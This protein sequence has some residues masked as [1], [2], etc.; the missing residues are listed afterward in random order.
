MKKPLFTLVAVLLAAA[1][2]YFLCLHLATRQTRR[3]LGDDGDTGA[4]PD[5]GGLG[6]PIREES[7][8]ALVQRRFRRQSEGCSAGGNPVGSPEVDVDR[9][10]LGP[11][12]QD[13]YFRHRGRGVLS[14][15]QIQIG[16]GSAWIR[17]IQRLDRSIAEK[18]KSG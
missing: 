14:Q 13:V 11:G 5:R 10:R 12:I 16:I 17:S 18:K 15:H 2:A 9:G 4:E 7:C 6:R 8:Q 3:M 1:A